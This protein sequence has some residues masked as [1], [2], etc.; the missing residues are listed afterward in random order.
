MLWCVKHPETFS[1]CKFKRFIDAFH[2]VVSYA[3][4]RL[5]GNLH[6]NSLSQ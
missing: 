4:S 1:K 5:E 2:L 3:N 6:E